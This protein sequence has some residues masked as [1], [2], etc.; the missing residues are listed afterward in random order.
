MIKKVGAAAMAALMFMAISVGCAR[1][2]TSTTLHTMS[3]D[4]I[5]E[6][7]DGKAKVFNDVVELSYK[8]AT[9]DTDYMA[10]VF[11]FSSE[12]CS[13][14][15]DNVMVSPASLLFA[16]E[17]AGAGAN[18]DTLDE[19]S[20]VMV[21]GATNE[22]ALGFASDYY[23]YLNGTD[24]MKISNGIFMNSKFD[25]HFYSDYL[26]Y[27]NDKFDAQTDIR[28]FDDD[29]VDF[30][31]AW[32]NEST[33]GMIP[34]IVSSL[35]PDLDMAVIV[36]AIA[37]NGEWEDKY[38]GEDIKED[39]IFT[40]ASGEDEKVTMLHSMEGTFFET[41]KATG[42]I[43]EYKDG[44]YAFVAIL[45]KDESINANEFLADFTADDYR[46]F[47]ASARSTDVNTYLPAFEYDYTN[48]ELVSV[49]MDMGMVAPFTMAADFSNMTDID[50]Y[51]SSVV[52]K[53][54]IEVDADGTKAA[55]ATAVTI[56]A[57]GAMVEPEFEEVYLNRPFAYAIVDTETE[58]PVF[59]GTVNSINK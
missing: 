26:D 7:V 28:K 13:G 48:Q 50:A 45:P 54:H 46:E 5:I 49:L 58:T 27:I 8:E 6:P 14:T 52:Q 32:V 55:A 3:A 36:N 29:A 41:D 33:D 35:D 1:P 17:M 4:N 19:M 20:N 10:F 53:T 38:E 2:N 15:D 57:K 34:S 24:E 12:C 18:G 43:K 44:D 59:L 16:L 31:N 40:N 23:K 42:F 25:G 37:F 11:N 56:T 51:I 21:P 30:I 22:E 39:Y 47:M 9:T